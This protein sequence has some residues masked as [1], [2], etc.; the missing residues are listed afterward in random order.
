MNTHKHLTQ[1]I[2]PV[3]F[4]PLSGDV[5]SCNSHEKEFIDGEERGIQ[6]SFTRPFTK[7]EQLFSVPSSK[8]IMKV[9][10]ISSLQLIIHEILTEGRVRLDLEM[11]LSAIIR[12]Y[13]CYSP[14]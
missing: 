6:F 2:K 8:I 9:F 10:N 1:T 11:K 4:K 13:C 5:V 3:G 12:E 7:G 14:I